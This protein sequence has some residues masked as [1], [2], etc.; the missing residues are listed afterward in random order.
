MKKSIYLY[1]ISF[2]IK[3]N[4]QELLNAG[5]DFKILK[6]KIE[7]KYKENIYTITINKRDNEY[8]IKLDPYN[9]SYFTTKIKIGEIKLKIKMTMFAIHENEKLYQ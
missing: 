2:I 4:R 6:D 9:K 5:Y 8:I 7:I 3:S 1:I